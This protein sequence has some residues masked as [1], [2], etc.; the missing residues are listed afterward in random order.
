MAQRGPPGLAPRRILRERCEG[1]EG[2]EGSEGRDVRRGLS[3]I[4][5][6][7]GWDWVM[8][9]PVWC[10]VVPVVESAVSS[11]GRAGWRRM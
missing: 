8:C 4:G 3:R 2:S 10:S 1:S 9:G 6:W 7:S 11:T 5:Q